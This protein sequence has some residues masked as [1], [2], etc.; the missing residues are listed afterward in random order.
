MSVTW[1]K[2]FLLKLLNQKLRGT[3]KLSHPSVMALYWVSSAKLKV[4]IPFSVEP[5]CRT[6]HER[7]LCGIWEV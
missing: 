5:W 7:N 3:V 4:N 6:A 1:M 2:M